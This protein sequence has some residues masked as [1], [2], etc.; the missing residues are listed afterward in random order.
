MAL[1]SGAGP[2]EDSRMKSF[3]LILA[4]VI[5]AICIVF[6]LWGVGLLPFDQASETLRRVL[7]VVGG[8][9]IALI[10]V[11]VVMGGKKPAGSGDQ[12]PNSG[13]SPLNSGPKF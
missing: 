7:L 9:G 12:N 13:D 1:D 4:F 5:L 2:G 11:G 8:V 10:G 6:C 3:R